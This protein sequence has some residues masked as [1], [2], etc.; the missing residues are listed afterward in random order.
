MSTLTVLM[1]KVKSDLDLE[2]E[3]NPFTNNKDLRRFFND[4][5][6]DAEAEIHNIFEDYFLAETDLTM[7]SGSSLVSMPTDIFANKIRKLMYF[8]PTLSQRYTINFLRNLQTIMSVD[9][10]DNYK[11]RII[12]DTDDGGVPKIKLFPDSQETSTNLKCYYLRNAKTFD[13][14]GSDD[15]E[16]VDIPEFERFLVARVKMFVYEKD[17][18]PR[19]QVAQIETERYRKMMVETLSRSRPDDDSLIQP[20]YSFYDDFSDSYGDDYA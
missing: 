1:N 18:D 10:S 9:S 12:N 4:S 11:Y 7:T 17:S 13:I 20:D 5:I 8:H 3:I 6:Q 19:F 14:D 15:S 2:D 16:N